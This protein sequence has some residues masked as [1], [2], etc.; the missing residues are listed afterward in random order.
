MCCRAALAD[1]SGS[2]L[3][4][5]GDMPLIRREAIAALYES[6]EDS[7]E[8]VTMATTVLDDPTGYGRI[9]RDEQ[10]GLMG[11]VEDADCS[12][13]QKLISEVNPSYYCFES[14]ALR[15][16]LDQLQPSGPKRE[17]YI[18]DAVRILREA[19]RGAS[20]PVLLPAE[21]AMGINS[22][23]DLVAVSRVMQDRLQRALLDEGVT[24]I[25]PDNT[26]VEA[27]VTVGRDTTIY[28]FSFIGASA[29][30]GAECRIGPFAYVSP[31]ESIAPGTTVGASAVG[32]LGAGT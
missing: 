25:D 18:T 12:P 21:D 11:I 17:Y 15:E 6:R 20:A 27:D 10:G 9:V 16:A 29:N 4:I 5:A 30:I 14:A 19:G 1:F 31:G 2:V 13:E 7:G 3:V 28:P 32:S 8:A 23:V 26:W 22:R 24:I